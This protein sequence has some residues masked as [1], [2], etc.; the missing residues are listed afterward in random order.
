MHDLENERVA[1]V[2]DKMRKSIETATGRTLNTDVFPSAS[3]YRKNKTANATIEVT[4]E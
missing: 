3:A 2:T 1:W 4:V